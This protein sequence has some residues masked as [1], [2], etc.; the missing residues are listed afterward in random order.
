MKLC[1]QKGMTLIELIIYS[2]LLSILI[3]SFLYFAV[4]IH[5]N[6]LDLFNEIENAYTS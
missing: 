1:T 5:I 6:N 3:A 2:S 4:T